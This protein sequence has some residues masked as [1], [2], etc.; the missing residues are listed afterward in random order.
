MIPTTGAGAGAAALAHA[1]K[2]SGTLVR[3]D[4]EAFRTILASARDPL[5][6]CA[7][8]GVFSTSY[9]YLM[10]Y[11]GLAFYTKSKEPIQLPGGAETVSVKSIWVP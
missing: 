3:V 1:V 8:G 10:G 6:V 11:K 9:Q 5:V 7:E 2:A 4:P